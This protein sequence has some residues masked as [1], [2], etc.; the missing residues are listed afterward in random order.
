MAT[1]WELIQVYA[2]REGLDAVEVVEILSEFLAGRG[3]TEYLISD[4]C[5]RI[6]EEGLTEELTDFLKRKAAE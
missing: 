5:E 6:E 3:S 1:A 4:I 2:R